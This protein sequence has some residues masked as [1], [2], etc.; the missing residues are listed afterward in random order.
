[1]PGT[2]KLVQRFQ[3]IH[4]EHMQG[5]PIV[6]PDL[7]VEAVGFAPWEAHELGV[8]IT[9]WFMNLVLLPDDSQYDGLAQGEEVE[10]RFPSGP[11]D[12]TVNQEEGVGAFLSAIL[13]RT[14]INFPGQTFAREVALEALKSLHTV[15]AV[16]PP[17]ISRRDI[18]KGRRPS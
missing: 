4:E 7:V 12:F 8:L 13:F 18:L 5:L 15:P 2:R 1:L 17:T 6:H 14:V 3:V 10:F 16:D 9:P 11:C